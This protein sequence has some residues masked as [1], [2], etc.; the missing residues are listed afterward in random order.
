V[1]PKKLLCTE[2]LCIIRSTELKHISGTM[3]AGRKKIVSKKALIEE[4]KH[5]KKKRTPSPAAKTRTP[6]PSAAEHAKKKLKVSSDNSRKERVA[7]RSN[8]QLSARSNS[9]SSARHDS[10]QSSSSSSSSDDDESETSPQKTPASTVARKTSSSATKVSREASSEDKSNGSAT[11]E[12]EEMVQSGH[13]RKNAENAIDAA[14]QYWES[15]LSFE[16]IFACVPDQF[17]S[18]SFLGVIRINKDEGRPSGDKRRKGTVSDG[19]N[20]Y[21]KSLRKVMEITG[22]RDFKDEENHWIVDQAA[23]RQKLCAAITSHYANAL[24]LKGCTG[25]SKTILHRDLMHLLHRKQSSAYY[26]KKE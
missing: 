2:Y 15:V 25:V 18:R 17:I 19:R 9:L 1:K 6:S 26:T 7:A 8:S 14:I 23:D 16:D 12:E 21:T 24:L 13:L 5:A 3:P 20:A 10:S 4:G 11:E 22:A